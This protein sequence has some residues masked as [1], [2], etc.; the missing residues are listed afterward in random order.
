M[1]GGTVDGCSAAR[2]FGGDFSCHLGVGAVAVDGCVK[3]PERTGRGRGHAESGEP[4]AA[5][6]NFRTV[7]ETP[8]NEP[9]PNETRN[10]RDDGAEGEFGSDSRCEHGDRVLHLRRKADVPGDP[11]G[12]DR[13]NAEREDGKREPVEH[14]FPRTFDR[15]EAEGGKNGGCGNEGEKHLIGGLPRREKRG[16]KPRAARGEGQKKVR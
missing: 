8:D 3:E 6:G 13:Q 5:P 2:E 14:V 11:I 7:R 16:E 9:E 15:D 12:P 10:D 1:P 4:G